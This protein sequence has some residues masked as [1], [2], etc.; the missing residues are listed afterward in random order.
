VGV[1]VFIKKQISPDYLLPRAEILPLVKN[2]GLEILPFW[3]FFGLRIEKY[4]SYGM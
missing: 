1:G 2:S 4:L 3:S